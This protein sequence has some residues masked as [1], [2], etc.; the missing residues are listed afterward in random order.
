MNCC[1][2]MCVSGQLL[3]ETNK[4]KSDLVVK[5][6]KSISERKARLHSD[7]KKK[8]DRGIKI[9]IHVSLRCESCP[10]NTSNLFKLAMSIFSNS[11]LGFNRGTQRRCSAKYL[12]RSGNSA[13]WQFINFY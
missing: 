13:G 6:F 8:N 11:I 9:F 7:N 10:L 1:R 2:L 4:K 3:S 12:F 5:F